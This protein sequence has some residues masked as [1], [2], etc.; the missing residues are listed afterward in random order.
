M[1]MQLQ[2]GPPVV[3]ISEKKRKSIGDKARQVKEMMAE[4]QANKAR[5]ET[6]DGQ[7][8]DLGDVQPEEVQESPIQTGAYEPATNDM[9]MDDGDNDGNIL[10]SQQSMQVLETL[11]MHAAQS[12]K[13]NLQAG[14]KGKFIDRQ[15]G[16]QRIDLIDDSPPTNGQAGP[17]HKRGREVDV[18]DDASSIQFEEDARP[19]VNK[20]A[21]SHLA[22]D[23]LVAAAVQ[24]TADVRQLSQPFDSASQPLPTRQALTHCQP[25]GQ[26]PASTAPQMSTEDISGSQDVPAGP[27]THLRPA[28]PRQ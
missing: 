22:N 21:R 16:A 8:E 15:T 17:S 26:A 18:D 3:H 25:R 2:G 4:V 27:G 24:F 10:A 19:Q 1:Q 28:R 11:R 23:D 6:L 20:R 9:G 5:R 13:E 14:R 12:N 7:R